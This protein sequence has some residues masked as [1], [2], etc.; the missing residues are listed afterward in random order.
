MV[1]LLGLPHNHFDLPDSTKAPKLPDPALPSVTSDAHAS[2]NTEISVVISP[3]TA[4]PGG[5]ELVK[6][7]DVGFVG[8]RRGA[9]LCGLALA[10]IGAHKLAMIEVLHARLLRHA[11]DI[12]GRGRGEAALWLPSYVPVEMSKRA[13]K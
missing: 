8:A 9:G 3:V 4:H 2:G 10:P 6:V 5:G 12:L 11:R 7:P 13:S 1:L